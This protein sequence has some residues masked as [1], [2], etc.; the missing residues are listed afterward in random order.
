MII[1]LFSLYFH[2]LNQLNNYKLK[3]DDALKDIVKSRAERKK[4][5]KLKKDKDRASSETAKRGF[6]TDQRISIELLNI[7]HQR[8]AHQKEETRLVGLSIHE[9]AISRQI[10]S[11]EARA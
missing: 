4:E 9:S 1:L 3:T 7:N 6:S 5:L 2:N 8:L 10:A 11:A